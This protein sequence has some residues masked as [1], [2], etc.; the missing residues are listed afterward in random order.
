[1]HNADE[2]DIKRGREEEEFINSLGFFFPKS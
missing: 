2:E 1:M